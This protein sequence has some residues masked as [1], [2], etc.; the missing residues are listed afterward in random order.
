MIDRSHFSA[1]NIEWHTSPYD[2][3]ELVMA[4]RGCP[5]IEAWQRHL[6]WGILGFETRFERVKKARYET[7]ALVER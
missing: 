6:Y 5:A 1:V 7:L 2:E 4:C 3:G